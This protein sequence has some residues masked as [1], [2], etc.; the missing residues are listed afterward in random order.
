MHQS[1]V[2]V[3][4]EELQRMLPENCKQHVTLALKK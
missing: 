2:A 4:K 3:E 1:L